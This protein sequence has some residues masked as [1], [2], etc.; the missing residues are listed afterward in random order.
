LTPPRVLRLRVRRSVALAV[1][2]AGSTARAEDPH[3]L[4]GVGKKPAKRADCSEPGSF[5]CP[6]QDDAFAR[7]PFALSTWLPAAYLRRLPVADANHDAVAHYA[8]GA[9]RDDAGLSF[10]GATGLENRWSLDGAPIQSIRTG[11]A[12]SRIPLTFLA[13]ITVTAGG[14]AARDRTSTGG[15]IDATLVKGGDTHDVDATVWGTLYDDTR[16]RPFARQLF[17]LRRLVVDSEPAITAS[18]VARGPLARALGGKLWYAAGVA[19]SLSPT[20]FTWTTA[21]LIDADRNG[22]PDGLPGPPVTQTVLVT[23][24]TTRDYV[25]P[26]ML[27]TGLDRG[28]HALELTLYGQRTHSTRFLANATQQAGG[29]DRDDTV[30]DGIA[31]YRAT[32]ARTRLVAQAAWHRSVHRERAHDDAAASLPQRLTAYIP[33]MV[34]DE[35]GLVELCRGS[36]AADTIEACAVPLGYFASGGAGPLLDLVGDRPTVTA[37]V[38]HVASARHTVFAGATLE[39]ARLAT[40]AR[41]T[42]GYQ[43]RSLGETFFNA[44]QRYFH[45]ECGDTPELPCN[46]ASSSELTYRTR[47][48]AAY[49]EDTWAP[50]KDL[51]V[52]GG[53][54]WELMWVGPRLHF[55]NQLAPRGGIAWD[56]LGGG[57]SRAWASYGRSYVALPAGL[58]PTVIR[59]DPTVTDTTITLGPGPDDSARGRSVDH[60]PS[61]SVAEDISPMTQDELTAGIEVGLARTFRVTAWVQA[62]WLRYGIETTGRGFDNPGREAGLPA[63][64]AS[65]LVAVEVATDPAGA[66]TLRAG[67]LAGKTLGNYL[68]PFDP[69]TGPILYDGLQFNGTGDDILTS[70]NEMGRLPTDVGHRLYVEADRRGTVGP[71]QLSVSTRLTLAS[72]RPRNVFGDTDIGVIALLPRGGAGRGAMLSQANVRV[73]ARWQGFDVTLDVF[74]AFDRGQATAVDELYTDAETR[75]I[76]GGGYEDLLWAKTTTGKEIG[77]RPAFGFPT[78]LQ[79]P[80]SAVLGV[81]RSF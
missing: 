37:D 22:T 4:F 29:L 66:F 42:G 40:R 75:A 18:V 81:H 49:L 23:D 63:R 1:L 51:R 38:T 43:L 31:T 65:E 74:N 9:S 19:P 48:A 3:D 68:G 44:E 72:G 13:G 27:R 70:G 78:G 61:Y 32:Y 12:E 62:R 26:A 6:W 76:E 47:Y 25:V 67:Y 8:L 11:G 46:Y 2:L 20:K 58:G 50:Q 34:P 55:S 56:P 5:G 69:R 41:Y 28:P 64:R 79:I 54:R 39:D 36:G 59:R 73:A 57:R 60:G 45:G 7:Q 16:R 71:V 10:A 30:L 33:S 24:E 35:P 77:R 17:F 14:F 21:R 53:L 15:M 52:D 80:V